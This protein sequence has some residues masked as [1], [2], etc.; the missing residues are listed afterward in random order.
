METKTDTK[1]ETKTDTKMDTPMDTPME[2]ILFYNNKIIFNDI[3][4]FEYKDKSK[5][6]IYNKK[7]ELIIACIIN[8]IIPE[9]YYKF[10]LWYNL[11]TQIDSYIKFLCNI[12]GIT[13]IYNIH[14][15][16][17]AGRKNNNDIDIS[18]NYI[19]FKIEFKYG[20]SCVNE[21]PQFSSPMNP[22]KY[23]NINFEAWFYDNYLHKISEFGNLD[24]PSKNI[25]CKTINKNEVKCM[26][27]YKLKYD[28]DIQ[29]NK[30]C[31]KIDKEA[32]EN[33]ITISDIDESKLT[34]YLLE[35]QKDKHY[36]CY[37]NETIY[38]DNLN[39]DLYKLSSIV[40]KEKTNYIYKTENGMKL[41]IKLRFKNGC[42]LQFPAF[43]IKRK[44]PNVKELKE[45]CNKHNIKPPKLKKDILYILD[46]NSI[47]Y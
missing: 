45:I 37:D 40:K 10:S 19:V 16:I 43:Q 22:S 9:Q 44:I 38:Y 21:T 46:K 28:N 27:K 13:I 8:N 24:I 35:T 30:Y 41:E 7:R 42:G 36:M 2:S 11:K 3:Y 6:D 17:K 4:V 39:T 26:K 15:I 25:Y 12:K 23:L 1:M 47:I 32:I 34:N 20:A 5:N 18:I 33:F 14:C 29:F 31:K